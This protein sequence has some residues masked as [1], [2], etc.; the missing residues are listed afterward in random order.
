ML[1]EGLGVASVHVLELGLVS[2]CHGMDFLELGDPEDDHVEEGELVADLHHKRSSPKIADLNGG[3]SG[4][5]LLKK[6]REMGIARSCFGA[7]P[8][9]W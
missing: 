3:L 1:H 6:R 2:H 8:F 9:V 7:L 4:T 5:V